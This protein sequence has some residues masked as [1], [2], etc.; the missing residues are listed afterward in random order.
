MKTPD[1]ARVPEAPLSQDLLFAARYYLGG[2]KGIIALAA[3]IVAAGAALNWS[4]LMAAGIAPLLLS[5]LPCLAMCV[6]GLC[7]SRIAG[8][9]SSAGEDAAKS[10][11]PAGPPP[12]RVL[13]A[14][15]A[16]AERIEPAHPEDSAAGYE[17]GGLAA[18]PNSRRKEM[19]CARI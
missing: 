5:V 12:P 8:T 1:T 18:N 4:W 14:V 7:M 10:A 6:L 9:S 2:R 3:L 15:A 17:A 13:P 19:T 11:A 16:G